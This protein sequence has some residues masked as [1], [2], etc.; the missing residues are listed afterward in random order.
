MVH[1]ARHGYDRR[2]MNPELTIPHSPRRTCS[3]F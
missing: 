1:G 2:Q 3:D